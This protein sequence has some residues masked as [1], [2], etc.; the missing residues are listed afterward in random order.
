MEFKTHSVESHWNRI[1]G[2]TMKTDIDNLMTEMGI[3]ALLITG[4]G[5]HNPFMVYF[6]GGVHLTQAELIKPRGK[7][8]FL[9]HGSMERD[10]AAKTGMN[11]R[12]FSDYM[13]KDF[14]KDA[15][16]DTSLAM[17]YRYRKMLKDAGIHTGKVALYGNID[18]G[19]G[20]AFFTGLQSIMPEI[21][22]V[23]YQENDLLQKAMMS[24][25]DAEKDR[26]RKMG[27]ITTGVIG[28]VADYLSGQ[29]ATNNILVDRNGDPI[30]IGKI[31]SLVNLWLAEG[32][33]ENPEG[34]IFA[35]GRDGGVPHSSGT[36][37]D[38]LQI[39][40]P[41]VFDIFPCE[42]GGGYFFDITRTWCLGFA[43][44]SV[45]QIYEQV[46]TVYDQIVS[47]LV[48][49]SPFAN[50][51]KRTCELFEAMGHP[52][53]LSDPKTEQGYVHTLGHGVGLHIHEKPS[54]STNG[55]ESD[56]LIPG[57][58]ITIEPGLYYPERGIGV[59]L[60]DTYFVNADGFEKAGSYPMDL[61]IPVKNR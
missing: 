5:D 42:Q 6:T 45:L 24:K 55:V 28:R 48:V 12:S 35:I 41:I 60:E 39:G 38:V 56:I 54:S 58:V 52:T 53:V 49:N 2:K 43:P 18:L 26:I 15:N 31:K 32:G 47:E 61:V 44:D 40:Q 25:D 8:A 36:A 37:T 3:D 21:T 51:Q 23:G 29:R 50:Y 14:L 4:A 13:I 9:F 19:K 16:N 27:E 59:R 57:S 33:A 17:A 1:K 46:K 10:E 22:F 7:K 11:T 20:Y 34:T 30:T